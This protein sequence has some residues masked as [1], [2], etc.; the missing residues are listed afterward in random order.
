MYRAYQDRVLRA[1]QE[2]YDR[3]KIAWTELWALYHAADHYDLHDLHMAISD[4]SAVLGE[5]IVREPSQGPRQPPPAP[6][7][8]SDD[9]AIEEAAR[10][11][12][13]LPAPIMIDTVRKDHNSRFFHFLKD[14]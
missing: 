12:L 1:H 2:R 10:A 3:N 4:A 5:I 9:A 11:L 8:P 14:R 13:N 7:E 6:L